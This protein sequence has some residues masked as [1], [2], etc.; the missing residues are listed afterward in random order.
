MRRQSLKYLALIL[1]WGCSNSNQSNTLNSYKLNVSGKAI[2]S[3]KVP[4][5]DTVSL[6][7]KARLLLAHKK[8]IDAMHEYSKLIEIDTMNGKYY[9]GKA[10]CLAQLD[11]YVESINYYKMASELEYD[12]FECFKSIGVIYYFMIKDNER[13]EEYFNKCLEINPKHKEV[14]SYLLDINKAGKIDL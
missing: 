14:E 7:L 11:Q 1:L 9:Y 3:L 13:A 2:D 10:Y 5:K 4:L 8:Y 12:R 6:N